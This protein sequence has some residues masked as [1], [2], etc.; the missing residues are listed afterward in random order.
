[1]LVGRDVHRQM[2]KREKRRTINRYKLADGERIYHQFF[3]SDRLGLVGKLDLLIQQ[4]ANFY[5]VEYKN[6][7]GEPDLHHRYQLTAYALLLEDAKNVIVRRGYIYMLEEEQVFSLEIT[8]SKKKYAKHLLHR[9]RS[10]IASETMPPP[11]T[12]RE[13]CIECEFKLYCGDTV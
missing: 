9:M 6:S 4:G 13:R 7:Y 3:Q 1:M 11:T 12:H 8:E 2:Y 10:M 5:P